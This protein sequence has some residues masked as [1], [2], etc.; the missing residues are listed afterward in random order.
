MHFLEDAPLSGRRVLLRIVADVPYDLKKRPIV[1][2]DFRLR[3]VMPTIHYLLDYGASVVLLSHLG[4]QDESGVVEKKNSLEPI[5]AHLSDLL[6]RPIK[7]A[8]SLF[9]ADTQRMVEALKPGEIMALENLR[10]DPGEIKNSRTFASKLARYGDLYVN[11]AFGV[12][13]RESA[14]IVALAGLLPCYG[15]LLLEREVQVL[16]SLM[17]NPARPYVTIVGGVKISDKM[18]TIKQFIHKADWILVGGGVAN[19][20]LKASGINVKDSVIDLEGLETAKEILKLGKGKLILPIDY[21]WQGKSIVDIGPETRQLFK[22]HL[23]P[24]R[25]IFWSGPLGKVEDAKYRQGSLEIAHAVTHDGATTVVGGGDTVS[26]VND[27]NLGRLFSFISTGGSA[28]L[29]Y[30]S[31]TNLPGLIAL[32]R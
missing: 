23:N 20:L 6:R 15:G 30:L 9:G 11:D 8:P 28:T 7:F 2:D 14:S 4:H 16:Y 25:T 19:T 18:P 29:E 10:F 12:S 27:A 26:F 5:Y 17:K 32:S 31:G 13:H 3:Q 22:K 1:Q 21:V 24:A